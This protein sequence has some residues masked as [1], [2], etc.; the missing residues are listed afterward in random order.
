M[1]HHAMALLFALQLLAAPTYAAEIE[2]AVTAGDLALVERLIAGGADVNHKGAMLGL[3]PLHYAVIASNKP[4]VDL[5][6]AKGADINIKKNDGYT[7]LHLAAARGNAPMVEYLLGKGASAA[8]TNNAGDTPLALAK[9][10][11]IRALLKGK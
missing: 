5:L 11:S 8:V 3:R 10:D 1:K 6:L 9:D 2:T 7:A 4:M